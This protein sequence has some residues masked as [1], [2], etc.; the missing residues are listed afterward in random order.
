MT[1]K[2]H[3]PRASKKKKPED[4]L[5]EEAPL[6]FF[7]REIEWLEFNSRVLHEAVDPRTP[8][9]ERV[10]FLGIFNSNLDE[11][12]MKRVGGL[13]H[14]VEANVQRKSGGLTPVQQLAAIRAKILP[15]LDT[16]AKLY[17]KVILPELAKNSVHLL[18]WKDLTTAEKSFTHQYFK[19][20]IFPVLTP[21]AVDPGLPFPFISNL[22]TSLGITLK[23]PERG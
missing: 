5:P 8:L 10:R 11:F 23:N 9:L 1:T 22:S 20:H 6:E 7:N 15:M 16:Q 13:K 2:I 17:R 14:R 18:E 19:S 4:L 12:F 3:R 21:L